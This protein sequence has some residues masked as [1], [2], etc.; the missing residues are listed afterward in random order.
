MQVTQSSLEKDASTVD[1]SINQ[2][3]TWH[4]VKGVTNVAK[5]TTL[6][7]YAEGPR[8]FQSVVLR[9]KKFMRKNLASKW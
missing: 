5:S 6:K 3:N 7:Q 1:K 9:K 8:P 2:D 4:M